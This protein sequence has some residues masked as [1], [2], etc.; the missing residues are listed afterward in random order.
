MKLTAKIRRQ[1]QL[2]SGLF[3][4][5]LLI[6]MGLLAWLSTHYTYQADWTLDNRH[7]LSTVSQELLA[8]MPDP[9][10]ITAYLAEYGQET[11]EQRAQIEHSIARFQRYKPNLHLQFV[12]PDT[13]RA[14]V[15]ENNIRRNGELL[16]RYQSRTENL[17]QQQF[18][19]AELTETLH[20]LA[21]PQTYTVAFL[22]GHGEPSPVR[23][24]DNDISLWGQHLKK[25]GIKITTLDFA[26][27]PQ[28]HEDLNALVI[29]QPPSTLSPVEVTQIID[30]IDQGGNLLWLIKSTETLQGLE[31]LA[32]KFGLTVQAG[33][34][35][36][37]MS[38]LF[39][40]S[41]QRS[42]IVVITDENYGTHPITKDFYFRTLLLQ[43]TALE[44]EP[45]ETWEKVNLM[46]TYP[47]AWLE[48]APLSTEV[49]EFN[50]AG[51]IPGPLTVAVALNRVVE[52]EVIKEIMT[53]S[54]RVILMGATDFLTNA[55]VYREGNL[56]MG[57]RLIDWLVHEDVF[58]EI[59][60]R[61]PADRTLHLSDSTLFWLKIFFLI[62][63]P[64]SLISTGV[65]IWISRKKA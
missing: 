8:Q 35:I 43:A 52:Q 54:Q 20:R 58:L 59:P 12:N 2:Q 23:F 22:A 14:E 34:I 45:P 57:L 19:E 38:Q 56:D 50:K 21:R 63:L 24:E 47:Q 28:L 53:E 13:A 9:I 6:I 48:Q 41:M 33:T 10:T 29:V 60:A 62:I 51:D 15:E 64:L 1:I 7:S 37:P 27:T 61:N 36:D 55:H 65:L 46:S 18:S 42:D 16:I 5:L 4:L 31:P 26:K 25:R 44:V 3:V 17:Y 32:E 49:I 40:M 11:Q 39:S 30:Y